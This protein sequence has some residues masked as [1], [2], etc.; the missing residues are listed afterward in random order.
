M[1]LLKP[2][3]FNIPEI[4]EMWGQHKEKL[5]INSSFI[6]DHNAS[7]TSYIEKTTPGNESHHEF[8]SSAYEFWE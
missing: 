1:S 7:Y 6:I 8:S 2:F 5:H 4:S 3:C